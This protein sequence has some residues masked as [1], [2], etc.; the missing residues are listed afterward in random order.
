MRETDRQ[1]L[2]S[3]LCRDASSS[4]S[5]SSNA[6]FI[7]ILIFIQRQLTE[8]KSDMTEKRVLFSLLPSSTSSF[9]ASCF[10]F[11]LLQQLKSSMS[12]SLIFF[13]CIK[14]T[15]FVHR[16]QVSGAPLTLSLYVHASVPDKKSLWLPFILFKVKGKEKRQKN[17]RILSKSHIFFLSSSFFLSLSSLFQNTR[18]REKE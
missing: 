5:T 14:S 12:S 3:L 4:F 2:T 15:L 8:K 18:Q 17:D 10:F 9:S 16:S 1:F 13:L 7:R 6:F 11:F